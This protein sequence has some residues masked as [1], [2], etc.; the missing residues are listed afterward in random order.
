MGGEAHI[1]HGGEEFMRVLGNPQGPLER[2]LAA[3]DRAG[4][5]CHTG[6]AGQIDRGVGGEA[7]E[8]EEFG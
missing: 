8:Q 1:H 2:Q 3:G 5:N 6:A 4:E 7:G